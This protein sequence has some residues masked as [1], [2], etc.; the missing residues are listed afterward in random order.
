MIKVFQ[1][2]LLGSMFHSMVR[3][4]Q[5]W[6]SS[7]YLCFNLFSCFGSLQNNMVG[8]RSLLRSHESFSGCLMKRQMCLTIKDK[9]QSSKGVKMTFRKLMIMLRQIQAPPGLKKYHKSERELLSMKFAKWWHHHFEVIG[10]PLDKHQVST[11]NHE[12]RGLQ[13]LCAFLVCLVPFT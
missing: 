2:Y 12:R 3:L 9:S 7:I 11:P 1:A 6:V 5:V 10:R 8:L 13:P 4:P